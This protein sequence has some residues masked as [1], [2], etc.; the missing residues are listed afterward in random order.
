MLQTGLPVPTLEGDINAGFGYW[1]FLPMGYRFLSGGQTYQIVN[2]VWLSVPGGVVPRTVFGGDLDLHTCTHTGSTVTWAIRILWSRLRTRRRKLAPGLHTATRSFGR[3]VSG[4]EFLAGP[5]GPRPSPA[6]SVDVASRA[7]TIYIVSCINYRSCR[8]SATICVTGTRG[9]LAPATVTRNGQRA[10]CAAETP[11]PWSQAPGH[12]DRKCVTVLNPVDD[13]C[14]AC[15]EAVKGTDRGGYRGAVLLTRRRQRSG[16]LPEVPV[17]SDA[18]RRCPSKAYQLAPGGSSAVAELPIPATV[19][20]RV[21]RPTRWAT[22]SAAR[23]AARRR[24]RVRCRSV[25]AERPIAPRW[26]DVRRSQSTVPGSHECPNMIPGP[27]RCDGREVD[28]R[29]P[30]ARAGRR[31]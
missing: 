16:R 22:A 6:R 21:G 14:A 4:V 10:R 13:F 15:G 30:H 20:I 12:A 1:S 2:R 27:E 11:P 3:R 29:E 28:G 25:G 26:R 19:V 31:R 24:R 5:L 9:G 7:S 23:R 18:R 17:P 8:R